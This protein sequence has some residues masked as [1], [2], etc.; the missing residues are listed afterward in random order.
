MNSIQPVKPSVRGEK[1]GSPVGVGVITI[2][3]VLL[4]LCLTI[5]STLTLTSA[6]ADLNLSHINAD[7][8]TA[9]YAADAQAAALAAAF[10]ADAENEDSVELE[11][12]IPISDTQVLYIHLLRDLDG[13]IQTLAWQ[14]I[15]TGE[16]GNADPGGN[17]LPVWDGT[18]PQ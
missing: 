9:Y 12:I 5:F 15:P 2:I 1:N 14:T 4:V 16:G 3:T 17:T 18:F 8:V 13:T 11:E 10:A 7:T 6:N